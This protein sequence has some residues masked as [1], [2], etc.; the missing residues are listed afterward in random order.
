VTEPRVAGPDAGEL[1]ALFAALTDVILVLDV[2]G[3][4]VKIAPSGASLLYRPA[5][6]LLGKTVHDV[7]P[8]DQAEFCCAA[9]R[10]TLHERHP[11][12]VEYSLRIEGRDVLFEGTVAPLD[13]NTVVWVA[14]DV[15]ER[16]HA[17][18]ARAA[19]LRISEAAQAAPALPALFAQ[20]HRIVG[21]LMPAKN[22]YI[23]LYDP[24]A[25][26]IS[27]P[28]FVDEFDAAPA[29]KRLGKGLTEYVLR[30]G[31][32]V[33]VTP[34]VHTALERAG[35]VELIGSPSVDWL[36]VPLKI[37]PVTIGVLVVQSYA[38]GT[39]Y[40]E[41]D[42]AVLQFVSSQAAMAIERTRTVAALRDSEERLRALE[43]ATTEGIVLHEDGVVVEVNDAFLRMLGYA[44]QSEVIGRSVLDFCAPAWRDRVQE[45]VRSGRETP[46]EAEGLRK[47]GTTI[48]GELTGRSARY[49]GR[50]VRM[51]AVRDITARR[52]LEA[53]L[54]QAQRMEAVGQLAGGVAHDFN[55][56]LTA[57]LASAD[58]LRSAVPDGTPLAPDLAIIAGAAQRGADLTKQL[59]AFSRKQTLEVRKV[60]LAALARSF[61]HMAR[62][63]VPE[64]V[65]V[66]V[67][68]DAAE[69]TI[70]AD[71]RAI[72]QILMNLVTN[73]RDAMPTGGRLAIRV[74]RQ[75]F[76]EDHRQTHGW[77]DPGDYATLTVSDT[78]HGMNAEVRRRLFEPFF[79]T[80]GVGQ[81][82]GL[83]LAMVYGLVKQQSGYVD[84]D[85]EPGR[86]TIVNLYF[87]AVAGAGVEH[88]V[89]GPSDVRGGSETVLLVEDDT[90]VR[91]AA[92][93]VLE[94]VGYRVLTA[95][96]GQ[97]ALEVMEAAPSPP[98]L[99]IS[100][101]VMPR[102]SGPN[103][104][105]KLRESGRVPKVLFTS[106]Y[107]A[108]DVEGRTQLEPG[109]PFL[110]KPWMV[111]DLL[112]KVREV[113]D[114]PGV[115]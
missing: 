24:A 17:E 44:D 58:A 101:V 55:N 31:Q 102:L 34:E 66:N 10:R 99:I 62:R 74:G 106:G 115:G 68:V 82:T 4:Y 50:D 56:L 110:A 111:A 42:K 92:T 20:I 5:A 70:E 77:G 47:D 9:I 14:R 53:Q 87:P 105:T 109:V 114:G 73:A 71:A 79:T 52:Q 90:A 19:M 2:D 81:G 76:G 112:C 38:E 61:S 67:A 29:P 3:R 94:R 75:A 16:R 95:V 107:T 86:G 41:A 108:R 98:D 60:S 80:K 8:K 32:P 36:G 65:E 40:T 91:R 27:F 46:Y 48:A 7:F 37:E 11:V 51:T 59:L 33:L 43:S 13:R 83:G 93:R 18:R 104:L 21:E 64:D 100:D 88:A 35:E 39:R 45:A 78:G 113:L 12:Q 30:T 23:A 97:A 28:Y 26:T 96:D 103:M 15:T 57:V 63:I 85:S 72:E 25:E 49:R 89:P 69:T 54:Q 1:E 84:V 6:E 22:I